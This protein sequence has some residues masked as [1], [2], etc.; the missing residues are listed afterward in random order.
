MPPI[1]GAFDDEESDSTAVAVKAASGCDDGTSKEG[2][3]TGFGGGGGEAVGNKIFLTQAGAACCCRWRPKKEERLLRTNAMCTCNSGSSTA[4]EPSTCTLI[5]DALMA[6]IERLRMVPFVALLTS[7]RSVFRASEA[8]SRFVV[9][10]C[11]CRCG[12][13]YSGP[14]SPRGSSPVGEPCS[15]RDSGVPDQRACC[16]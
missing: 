11:S 7:R 16:L 3:N 4:H 5:T 10:S 15:F 6:C 12:V 9:M 14:S 2:N 8:M 1:T 13:S